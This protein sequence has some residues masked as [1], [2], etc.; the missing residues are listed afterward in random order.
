MEALLSH[1]NALPSMYRSLLPN[2][3]LHCI[4]HVTLFVILALEDIHVQLALVSRESVALPNY[5][6]LQYSVKQISIANRGASRLW[7]LVPLH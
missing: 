5:P 3:R 7:S 4:V 6:L 1:L 2:S